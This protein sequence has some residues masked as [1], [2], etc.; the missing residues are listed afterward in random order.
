MKWGHGVGMCQYGAAV[1]AANGY[2][3]KQILQHYYAGVEVGEIKT[4]G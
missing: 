2:D 3:Y 4:P 1:L